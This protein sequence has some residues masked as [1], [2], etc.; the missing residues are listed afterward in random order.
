M[1]ML[2]EGYVYHYSHLNSVD[3]CPYSFYMELIETEPDGS[4]KE[5][6]S[7]FFAEYGTM[8][9]KVLE[10]WA[11]GLITIDQMPDEYAAIYADYVVTPPPPYMV[12]YKSKAYDKG[13]DY[14]KTFVGFPGLDIVSAEEHFEMDFPLSDGTTRPLAGTIDLVAR[15]HETGRLVILDHKSKSMKEFKKHRDEMYRQQY[16]Y[17]AW[18]EHKYGELPSR[19]MFNL[20]KESVLDETPFDEEE[21]RR[22]LKWAEDRMLEMEE[23]DLFTWLDLKPEPDFFCNEVCSVR[24]Y[25]PN[26]SLKPQP[27]GRKRGEV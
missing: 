1:S 24:K 4:P 3:S 19:L 10:D 25:C 17:S 22:T 23:R 18:V 11:R 21:Y 26:G 2:P 5:L 27:K 6:Q 14:F 15:D 20:F 7:N 8:M 13:L 12:A 16:L 9:H